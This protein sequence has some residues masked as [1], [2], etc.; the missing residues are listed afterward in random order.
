MNENPACAIFAMQHDDDD[1]YDGDLDVLWDFGATEIAINE[2]L[3]EFVAIF[4]FCV[5]L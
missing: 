5:W 1:H 4:R 3:A 2:Q